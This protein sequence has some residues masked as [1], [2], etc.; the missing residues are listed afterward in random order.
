MCWT[1]TS[2]SKMYEPPTAWG[3]TGTF[4]YHT[5]KPVQELRYDVRKTEQKQK[6]EE[7]PPK[8]QFYG[9]IFV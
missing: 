2:K 6:K 1:G 7:K 3:G 8:K 4:G 5:Q 9:F